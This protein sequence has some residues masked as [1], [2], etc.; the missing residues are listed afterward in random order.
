[1]RTESTKKLF[2]VAEYYQMAE[3]GILSPQD[4]VELIDGEIIEITPIG[5]RHAGYI[6]RA[7]RLFHLAFAGKAVVS[8]QN[9]LQ[10][11]NYTEPE[12][13]LVVLKIRSD[14]YIGKKVRAEDALLVVEVSDTTLRYDR[15]IKLPSYAAAGVPEVWI[16]DLEKHDLLVFRNPTGGT[17]SENLILQRGE[18][19]SPEAF[20]EIVFDIDD[21][22]G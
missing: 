5:D 9:P 15:R 12:P 18:K 2:T 14:D 20:P 21:L 4:R 22:L 19:V 17:Y 3:A 7:A 1:M 13:D 16:E 8:V 10:L 6:N 11:S